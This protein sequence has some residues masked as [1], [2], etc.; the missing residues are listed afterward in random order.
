M[1]YCPW[2]HK[3]S[4]ITEQLSARVKPEHAC[5]SPDCSPPPAPSAS[6]ERLG[7]EP[8]GASWQGRVP[9]AVGTGLRVQSS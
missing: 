5:M 4:E 3:E 8:R 1:G 6:T 2:G 7:E 9:P